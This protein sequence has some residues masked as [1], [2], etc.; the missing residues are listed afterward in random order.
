MER[1]NEA[2]RGLLTLANDILELQTRGFIVLGDKYTE[3]A[4]QAISSAIDTRPGDISSF[5]KADSE[6]YWDLKL[7]CESD[8]EVVIEDSSGAY[9]ILNQEQAGKLAQA[10]Q[11]YYLNGWLPE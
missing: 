2:T 8:C 10:L 3:Q 7:S 9:L 11:H 1:I 5:I 6:S 4:R